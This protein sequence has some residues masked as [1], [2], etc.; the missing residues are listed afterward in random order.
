MEDDASRIRTAASAV[1][2]ERLHRLVN[3]AAGY[4]DEPV[5]NGP[6]I[7]ADFRPL[8]TY[9]GRMTLSNARRQRLL[10]AFQLEFRLSLKTFFYVMPQCGHLLYGVPIGPHRRGVMAQPPELV[11]ISALYHLS[12]GCTFQEGCI[13][14]RRGI[15]ISPVTFN[16]NEGITDSLFISTSIFILSRYAG[17]YLSSHEHFV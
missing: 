2:A 6:G 14:V 9:A 8:L 16:L 10:D 3:R 5:H 1:E 7:Y 12:A 15:S 4:N 17:T 13:A 11:A